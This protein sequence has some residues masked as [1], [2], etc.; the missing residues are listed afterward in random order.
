MMFD[1]QHIRPLFRLETG[2]PGS[3][4]AV[5]I[6]RK[7]GLPEEIIRSAAEKAGRNTSTSKAAARNRARQTLLGTEARPHPSD[8]PQGGGAGTELCG[9]A[10]QNPRRTAGDTQKAK[11]EAQALIAD[12]N[13]QIENTIR[14]IRETQAEKETTRLARKELDDVPCGG[15]ARRRRGTRRGDSPRNRT[16]RTPPPAPGRTQGA[17]RAKRRSAGS[18]PRTAEET[19]SRGGFESPRMLGQEMVGVSRAVK[20]K[21]A[22]VA[23]GQILTTVDK[24]SLTVV[25]NNEYR[26]ATRPTTMRTV[27]SADI[28]ARKLR[29]RDRIDVRGMRSIEAP[30][31]GAG[32]HRRRADGGRRFGDDPPRQGHRRALR[33]RYAAICARCPK[34]NR[35]RTNM[36]TGAAQ[37]SRW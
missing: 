31:R 36:P 16:H 29:F 15:R 10:G 3:S 12:A 20:G 13:R 23:F 25:S 7:I 27:V 24:A 5:E 8:R 22:Q 26:E 2:K 4:F 37:A 19:R 21:K 30:R 35:P 17:A 33:R 9:T 18:A 28:S 14:T 1:V 11:Q 6:A 32:V 34:W